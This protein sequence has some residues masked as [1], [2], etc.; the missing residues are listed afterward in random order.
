MQVWLETIKHG[1]LKNSPFL[2][3][4]PIKTSIYF[5]NFSAMFDIL[6]SGRVD[7]RPKSLLPVFRILSRGTVQGVDPASS[8]E[9]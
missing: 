1:L 7:E 9:T 2:D 6:I 8:F 4:F 3:D 5:E